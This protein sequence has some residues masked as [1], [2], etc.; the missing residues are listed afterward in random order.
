MQPSTIAFA[1]MHASGDEQILRALA[2]AVG[3]QAYEHWFDNK[4]SINVQDDELTI[5][6]ASPFL[7]D[8]LVKQFRKV[9]HSAVQAV[10]GPS[11]RVR[12]TVDPEIARVQL[13]NNTT[14]HKQP[15]EKR[16]P[17]TARHNETAATTGRRFA[18]LKDFIKG[19]CNALALT[20]ARQVCESA[21]TKFNPLF[22]HGPV[23]VG[24]THL[25]EGIYRRM[26]RERTHSC[27]LFI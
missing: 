10:L 20:A 15:A 8:W 3:D 26:R 13:E 5:G 12:F 19:P 9:V 16:A 11:S 17:A 23:G 6:V 18:D 7:V 24:K 1:P 4:I 14:D 25:L 27:K 21:D 22:V 2:A